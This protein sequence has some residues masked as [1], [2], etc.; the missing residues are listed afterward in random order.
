M[1]LRCGDVAARY[2]CMMPLLSQ[3]QPTAKTTHVN[4]HGAG[5]VLASARL[6]EEGV[7]GVVAAADRVVSGHLTVGLDAVLCG[8]MRGRGV[9]IHVV[10]GIW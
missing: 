1:C 8:G 2:F 7:E 6:R 5:D 9:A 3:L 4:E 10:A